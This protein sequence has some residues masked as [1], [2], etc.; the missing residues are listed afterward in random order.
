[1]S[2]EYSERIKKALEVQSADDCHSLKP[3]RIRVNK[4]QE[5]NKA[6]NNLLTH[7]CTQIAF[8]TEVL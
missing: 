3:S 7:T 8:K 1:M 2:H 6:K 4:E 5:G